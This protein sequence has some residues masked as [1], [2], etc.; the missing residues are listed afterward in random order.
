MLVSDLSY[1]EFILWFGPLFHSTWK[2][3]KKRQ[4]RQRRAIKSW[5]PLWHPEWLMSV[6][7]K[8]E[9]VSPVLPMLDAWEGWSKDH[10]KESK[11]GTGGSEHHWEV[12]LLAYIIKMWASSDLEL[13]AAPPTSLF[14]M[15]SSWKSSWASVSDSST[16]KKKRPPFLPEQSEKGSANNSLYA[17]WGL[18]WLLWV[19]DLTELKTP[20][21]N[22]PKNTK[23][24]SSEDSFC[25]IQE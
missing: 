20:T 22:V 19:R 3:K 4:Q 1:M 15:I 6:L 21:S 7:G 23:G 16:L 25:H 10:P 24:N 11:A 14:P 17:S 2:K 18:N 8:E 12:L 5:T 9:S 13:P